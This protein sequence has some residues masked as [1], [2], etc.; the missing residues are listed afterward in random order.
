VIPI[1]RAARG[2]SMNL[3]TL[4]E[5][6]CGLLGSCFDRCAICLRPYWSRTDSPLCPPCRCACTRID[7][8]ICFSD[9]HNSPECPKR[10]TA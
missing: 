10:V 6:L 4:G 2:F 9:A 8:W 1:E 5:A 7:C 3:E